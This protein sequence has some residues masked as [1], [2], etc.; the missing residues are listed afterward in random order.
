MLV[1]IA[2]GGD[3]KAAAKKADAA[4]TSRLNSR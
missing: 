1:S 3:V 2:R 4:I